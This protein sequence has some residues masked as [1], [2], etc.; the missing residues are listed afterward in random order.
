MSDND[1]YGD[2]AFVFTGSWREFA[3]IA[4][5]NLLLNIVTLG[6]YR[7]W[8]KTRERQY[9]WG[10]TR[11][12]GDPLEWTGTGK[13][14]FIGFLMVIALFGP[15][16]LFLQFGA[17][18]LVMRGYP[19]IAGL[20]ALGMFVGIFYMIGVARFRAL[21]YRLGRTFWHG[22]RGGSND[23]GFGYGWSYVWKTTLGFLA[24]GVLVPRASMSL[25]NER[26]NKMSFGPHEFACGGDYRPTMLRYILIYAVPLIGGG[27]IG[28][29]V[30]AGLGAI[31]QGN[32]ETG[33]VL[34]VVA[35]VL[36]YAGIGFMTLR[37]YASFFCEGIKGLGLSTLDFAFEAGTMDWVRLVLGDIALVIGTL[38]IGV[39]FLE[40]RHWKFF[41]THL[42]CYGEVNLDALTQSDTTL[43]KQGE[44]LLDALDVGAF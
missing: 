20:L 42:E 12:I 16:L 36:L 30:I 43:S 19:G 26:W 35:V 23:G 32:N 27:I 37:Y 10:Q 18:A 15:P 2:S 22:I 13:E 33:A 38:G 21:R 44:G 8:A 9:L 31:T 34:G 40:Y 17:Q 4:F 11:F 1:E 24:F 29:I 14:L 25:W 41:V 28:F 39:I 5:T 6:I 3:P 7:F